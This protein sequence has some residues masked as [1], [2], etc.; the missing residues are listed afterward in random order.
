MRPKRGIYVHKTIKVDFQRT[1]SSLEGRLRLACLKAHPRR[2]SPNM[3]KPMP[4]A[5]ND[6]A[7]LILVCSRPLPDD[8]A[9]KRVV[10]Q[11]AAV[12]AATAAIV[13]N[14]IPEI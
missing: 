6:D 7:R 8:F 14:K 9:R 5:T 13:P 3:K 11:N 4:N 2:T 1:A 12:H 10:A